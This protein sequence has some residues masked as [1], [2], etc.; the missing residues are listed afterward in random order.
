MI[1]CPNGEIRDR[2]PD[3]VHDQLDPPARAEVSAHVA[4]CA[5]CAAEVTLLRELRARLRA[6]PP[7]D[8]GQIVAAL[9][10][11]TASRAT[12]TAAAG[13]RR[14]RFD[15]RIAAALA[16]LAVG[17]GSAAVWNLWARADRSPNVAVDAPVLPRGERAERVERVAA[18]D[19]T[20]DADLA[21][22]SVAELESLLEELESFDGLP[23]GEPE[24]L[25]PSPG[26][27]GNGR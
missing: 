26:D 21:E 18:A 25:L 24:P 19:L 10:R 7:V 12:A 16:A 23:A 8:V 6:A 1:D 3:F 4:T 15:W 13:G 5:P 17:G 22:V 11:P 27:E 9:P 2:L 14:Q 20:I